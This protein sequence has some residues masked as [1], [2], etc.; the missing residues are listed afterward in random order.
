MA[1][2]QKKKIKIIIH[3]GV[4]T[5]RFAWCAMQRYTTLPEG[6]S[7]PAARRAVRQQHTA[8]SPVPAVAA[9]ALRSSTL[10]PPHHNS[11]TQ[12]SSKPAAP[13]TD[14]VSGRSATSCHQRAYAEPV[15]CSTERVSV[16]GVVAA[17]EV[18]G[19]RVVVVV[20]AVVSFIHC[21]SDNFWRKRTSICFI[22]SSFG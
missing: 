1:F 10:R 5:V 19:G 8:P 6:S 18:T 3:A 15:V 7:S 9:G 16:V 21:A 11:T 20:E 2:V 12:T 14:R 4:G 13:N 17:G 22:D